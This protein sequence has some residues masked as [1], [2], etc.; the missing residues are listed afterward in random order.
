MTMNADDK[1][2]YEWLRQQIHS[3]NGLED[4]TWRYR[5]PY[6]ALPRAKT[7]DES[8]DLAMGVTPTHEQLEEMVP[9]SLCVELLVANYGFYVSTED[10]PCIY[11]ILNGDSMTVASGESLQELRAN[12]ETAVRELAK[13][14]Q[15]D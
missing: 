13:K 1:R 11:E 8:I 3:I 6:S 9:L 14:Q 4:C 7:L 2:R 15:G 10:M 5:M 12:I